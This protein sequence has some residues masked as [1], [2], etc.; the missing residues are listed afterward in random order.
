MCKIENDKTFF[1][2]VAVPIFD[3]IKKKL[4]STHTEGIGGV[5]LFKRS[6]SL[7][8]FLTVGIMAL[9]KCLR[10]VLSHP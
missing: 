4:S 3:S 2:T 10:L 9:N 7:R 1:Q 5:S 6:C 8:S